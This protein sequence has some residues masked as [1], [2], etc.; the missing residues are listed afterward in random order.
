M[1]IDMNFFPF[2]A[3]SIPTEEDRL[4]INFRSIVSDINAIIGGTLGPRSWNDISTTW[5]HY[6]PHPK[7]RAKDK[8]EQYRPQSNKMKKMY[9]RARKIS[10]ILQAN[11]T[12]RDMAYQT[13][14]KLLMKV[15]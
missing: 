3:Y 2:D 5:A 1:R 13:A 11:G 7:E 6:K 15:K 8:T 4:D 14:L 12:D 10:K 9:A